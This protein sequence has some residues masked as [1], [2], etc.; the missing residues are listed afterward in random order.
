MSKEPDNKIEV[1]EFMKK[2]LVAALDTSMRVQSIPDIIRAS[3]LIEAFLR[4]Y[5]KDVLST[6]SSTVILG[7]SYNEKLKQLEIRGHTYEVRVGENIRNSRIIEVALVERSI[8][9]IQ[10]KTKPLRFQLP[11]HG[12]YKRADIWLPDQVELDQDW[13]AEATEAVFQ[14]G[15]RW[16]EEQVGIVTSRPEVSV[17]IEL[18]TYL[19]AV[20]NNEKLLE[21]VWFGCSIKGRGVFLIDR[22]I[23]TSGL[24]IISSQAAQTG[25][26]A[27]RLI[28]EYLGCDIPAEKTFGTIAVGRN[29]CMD[30]ELSC[31][32]YREDL[33][34]FLRVQM[35]V[36]KSNSITI[37]PIFRDDSDYLQ[38]VFPAE[39]KHLLLAILSQ[40]QE[41]LAYR[42]ARSRKHRLRLLK[43]IRAPK[44][45]LH[46]SAVG[47]FSGAFL[48]AIVKEWSKP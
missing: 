43:I 8:Q 4:N 48:G 7:S 29:K 3:Q 19:R 37:F 23:A 41:E 15:Y 39:K 24:S 18:Y 12:R 26:S 36:M 42:F 11:G 38:C 17:G 30:F 6:H 2:E 32:K 1:V 9:A 21:N 20:V 22:T 16:L 28:A 27:L 5:L 33:P 47:S 44:G 45:S 25:E 10:S 34:L 31:A 14:T 13:F 40:H 46:A 35:L